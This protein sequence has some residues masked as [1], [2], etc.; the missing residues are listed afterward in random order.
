MFFLSLSLSFSVFCFLSFFSPDGFKIFG[1]GWGNK[2]Y[3]LLWIQYLC[4]YHW[5]CDNPADAEM[6]LMYNRSRV[7]LIPG[8]TRQCT[9]LTPTAT[10]ENEFFKRNVMFLSQ[11]SKAHTNTKTFYLSEKDLFSTFAPIAMEVT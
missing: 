2:T 6:K 1:K 3:Y 5:T 10:F 8:F 9:L 11:C 7:C 4:I